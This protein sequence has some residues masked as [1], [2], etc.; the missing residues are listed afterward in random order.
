MKI[1]PYRERLRVLLILYFFSEEYTEPLE[2]TLARV[3][4]SEVKIQKV[5]FLLRYPSYLCF[6]LLRLHQET[7]VPSGADVQQIVSTVFAKGEPELRTDEMKRFFYGAYQDLDDI[8]GFLKSVGLV[9]F[10]KQ[11]S[12]GLK[13]IRKAYFLTQ[14]GIQR[15]ERGLVNVPSASWYFERCQLIKRYFADA[16]GTQLKNRQYAIEEYRET[17]LGDYIQDIEAMV[18]TEYFTLFNT[19]L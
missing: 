4:Y 10:R 7:G 18:R 3:F 14:D 12:M 2:P 17:P 9:E 6:E 16:S 13:D 8:I 15:I 1:A 11:T 19:Q 5:D